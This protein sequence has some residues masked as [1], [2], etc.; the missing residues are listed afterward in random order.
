MAISAK[1]N[2]LCRQI[3]D[4]TPIFP[5]CRFCRRPRFPDFSDFLNLPIPRFCRFP[6]LPTEF[7]PIGNCRRRPVNADSADPKLPA[8]PEVELAADTWIRAASVRNVVAVKRHHVRKSFIRA[9]VVERLAPVELQNVLLREMFFDDV[10]RPLNEHVV[11]SGEM[12]QISGRGRRAERVAVVPVFG[13]IVEVLFE[14]L[15][16]LDQ[17]IRHREIV[18][19]RFFGH[20]PAARHDF[21]LAGFQQSCKYGELSYLS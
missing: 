20:H 12:V 6:D 3:A 1:K 13:M 5:T 4:P 15:V 16:S 14:P 19:R 10:M 18:A 9:G 8:R 7:R 17:L 11:N 2:Q 21:D